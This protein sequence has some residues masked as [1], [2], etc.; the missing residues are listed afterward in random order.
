MSWVDRSCSIRFLSPPTS[1]IWLRRPEIKKKEKEKEK[2]HNA[3]SYTTTI[4]KTT[5]TYPQTSGPKS[6]S[7]Y[8]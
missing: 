2:E 6:N 5:H 3:T 1:K 7:I 4:L 8:K